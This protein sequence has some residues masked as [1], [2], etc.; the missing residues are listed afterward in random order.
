MMSVASRLCSRPREKGT[1]QYV[2]NLLQPSI[3]GTKATYF[4]VRVVAGMSHLSPSARSSRSITRRSPSRA[5]F[6][7]SG[8]RSVARVPTIRLTDGLL[9]KR[10][11]PSN[12]ATQ[13]MT[14]TTGSMPRRC[15]RTSPIRVKTLWAAR[16][17]TEQV[18]K[19]TTSA[20]S[21]DWHNSNPAARKRTSARSLSATFI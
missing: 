19:I 18:L 12:C 3:M 15:R 20:A 11:F 6:T 2:Q 5:R 10:A 9:S 14:P 7:N 17:R 21:G 1:I 13:P 16:S 4:E 8:S